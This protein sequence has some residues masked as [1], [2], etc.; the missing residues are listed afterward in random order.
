MVGAG[1]AGLAAA[2]ELEKGGVDVIV[3]EAGRRPGG[4]IVTERRDGFIVEGGPDGFL[5][6]ER[7]IQDVARELGVGDRLVSPLAKGSMLWTGERLEPLGEGRAAELLGIQI[8]G[9]SELAQGFKTFAG[10]MADFV[11][12][13]VASLGSAVRMNQGVTA[14][15]P[16]A[17]GWRL[18]VTGGSTHEAE[19]VILAVPAWSTARFLAA[20]GVTAGRELEEVVY[21]PSITVSLAYRTDQ[22]GQPLE[23]TGFVVDPAV[24]AR[25]GV[26]L[27]V[28]ACTYSS[29]KYPD[30]AP[31][32]YALLRAFVG[33]GVG[34]GDPGAVTHAELV[35][36]LRLEGGP[37]WTRVFH[38]PRGLPRYKPGHAERVAH[39][40][41]RLALLAPLEI[42]GAAVD[43][44]GVSACVRSGREAARGLIRRLAG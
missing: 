32:G 5:A 34:E 8:A 26:P 22:I 31:P 14:L 35:T 7:D 28:R 33:P 42:A 36:I 17:R 41:R 37:L 13:L 23:G 43:G 19:G 20:L 25:H 9:E 2:W 38:W 44:A 39:I 4:V 30:R 21:H 15:A 11:E 40:R 18:A 1:L 29:S 12:A 10:G 3:L 24:G 16:A 6:A 27:N